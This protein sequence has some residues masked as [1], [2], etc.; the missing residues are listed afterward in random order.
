MPPFVWTRR[1]ADDEPA[2]PAQRKDTNVNL[3]QALAALAAAQEKLGAE[4]ARADAADA[5][6]GDLQ[7]RHDASA[8]QLESAKEELA[9]AK[10]ARTDAES[11]LPLRVRA[12]VELETKAR[13][14]LGRTDSEDEGA[15]PKFDAMSDRELKLA[16]VKHVTDADCDV[17]AKG[18]KRSDEY[19]N[20]RYDAAIE[21]AATS[22]DTFR[23]A[24]DIIVGNHSHNDG[25]LDAKR[26][27][28]DK[29]RQDMIDAN[30][31]AW[32]T[33]ANYA[34]TKSK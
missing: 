4:K 26:V 32:R 8:A 31:N 6:A 13:E 1:S 27:E 3:E 19:V 23:A 5:K 2:A 29:A 14:I 11:A 9:A 18:A 17:D 10:K 22:A 20:A 12:R 15:E 24:N 30:R 34:P 16:V 7:K 28:T 25:G 21:R 33:D